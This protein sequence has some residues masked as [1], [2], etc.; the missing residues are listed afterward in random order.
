MLKAKNYI[1]FFKFQ[2]NLNKKKYFS[3]ASQF[4]HT[5]IMS[6]SSRVSPTHIL[7]ARTSNNFGKVAYQ[8]DDLHCK[9]DK[10]KPP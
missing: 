10:T 9:C 8:P 5:K 2:L 1:L 6:L 3:Y 7:R 4:G